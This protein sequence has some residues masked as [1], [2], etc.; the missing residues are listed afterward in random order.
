MVTNTNGLLGI[1]NFHAYVHS[2]K[3]Q[4]SSGDLKTQRD[5]LEEFFQILWGCF[6]K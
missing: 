4:P 5:N 6:K 3:T 1:P 2:Y